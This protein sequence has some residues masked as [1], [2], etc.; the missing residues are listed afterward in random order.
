MFRR[1]RSGTARKWRTGKEG[2]GRDRE[3]PS[4]IGMAFKRRCRAASDFFSFVVFLLSTRLPHYYYYLSS[5]RH[6]VRYQTGYGMGPWTDLW[7]TNG[8][9]DWHAL[10]FL[11]FFFGSCSACLFILL[12]G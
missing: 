9:T 11:S 2:G 4:P 7:T 8:T 12:L 10:F 1:V 3:F 6:F 5:P